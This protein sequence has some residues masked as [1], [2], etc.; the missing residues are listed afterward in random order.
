MAFGDSR[1]VVT[2]GGQAPPNPPPPPTGQ[3]S[4]PEPPRPRTP[5]P[6]HGVTSVTIE[7][8]GDYPNNRLRIGVSRSEQWRERESWV[9]LP[10]PNHYDSKAS[11]IYRL[12]G[13]IVTL[14]GEL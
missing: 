11:E 14:A 10:A 2:K 4:P 12:V 13:E 7:L 5:S 6:F 9:E 3:A 8:A 1:G